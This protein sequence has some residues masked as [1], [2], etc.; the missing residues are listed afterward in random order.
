MYLKRSTQIT[1]S[2]C[3]P[4]VVQMLL[5]NL[6]IEV[7]QEEITKAAD[8]TETIEKHGVT[9]EQMAKAVQELAPEVALYYKE[10]ASLSDIETLLRI[11]YLPVGVEWQGLFYENEAEEEKGE[12]YGHYSVVTHVDYKKKALIIVDPY[13]DFTNSDRIISIYKFMNRWWDTNELKDP[14]SNDPIMLRDEKL[15]FVIAYRN[16]EL[17]GKLGLKTYF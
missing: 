4:A 9:I 7:T 16:P 11:Y 2:H 14:L 17:S 1:D 5:E 6:G 10:Y 12:D 3:G 13:R 15:L 8:A